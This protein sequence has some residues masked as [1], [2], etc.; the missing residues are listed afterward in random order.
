MACLELADEA[1]LRCSNID[2]ECLGAACSAES[3]SEDGM[4]LGADSDEE[5]LDLGSTPTLSRGNIGGSAMEELSVGHANDDTVS[6]PS[7]HT[8]TWPGAACLTSWVSRS[9]P[10]TPQ[11]QALVRNVWE[12]VSLLPR[13]CLRSVAHHLGVAKGTNS[14]V[15]LVVA[16]V[17]GVSPA[18]VWRTTA[19]SRPATASSL[20]PAETTP[21]PTQTT[22]ACKRPSPA[23][24]FKTMLTLTRAALA[25]RSSH[26]GREEYVRHLTRLSMEGVE[27]GNRFHTHHHLADVTYLAARC[28][29]ALDMERL[30]S[31]LGGLGIPS[32]FAL[33]FDGVPIGS[34][35]S[36]GRHGSVV[37]VCMVSVSPFTHQLHAWLLTSFIPNAGHGGEAI[38]NSLKAALW[39]V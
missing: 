11:S 15:L 24:D 4:R 34:V 18:R 10:L 16:R 14:W 3:E 17:L 6:K 31:P 13:A 7:Q 8:T 29:Q 32:A 20:P 26:G 25:V 2:P 9:R 28:V 19:S 27:V 5:C 39:V 30:R 36:F 23:D 38:A 35:A 33:C 1:L 12:V 22:L 37:V 21:Q